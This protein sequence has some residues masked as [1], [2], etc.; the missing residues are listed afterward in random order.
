M[1]STVVLINGLQAAGGAG[2]I[3]LGA[4]ELVGNPG[5]IDSFALVFGTF[6]FPVGIFGLVRG[7]TA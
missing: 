4:M 7:K 5:F 6:F 1:V 2:L 3:I